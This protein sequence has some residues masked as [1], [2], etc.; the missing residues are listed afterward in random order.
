[1]IIN[2]IW[3]GSLAQ[4]EEEEEEDATAQ[5]EGR[6]IYTFSSQARLIVHRMK[7]PR[8]NPISKP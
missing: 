2:L 7:H 5:K 3:M 4:N 8:A 6:K 1:M